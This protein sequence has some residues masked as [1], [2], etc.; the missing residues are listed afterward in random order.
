VEL[1]QVRG[2]LEIRITGLS[3]DSRTVKPG[4][5]FFALTGL[6]TDGHNFI[7]QAVQKG[8]IAVVQE[9]QISEN[10]ALPQIQ[11]RDSRR[12]LA[13]CSANYYFRPADYLIMFAVTGTDGKTT[14]CRLIQAIMSSYGPVGLMGTVGH[15]I[16]GKY[17]KA[18][19]TTPEAPEI[20]SLLAR[21]R[22]GGAYSAV[23]EVSSHALV[24]KRVEGIDFD[25]ATFTNLGLD[26]LDF[27]HTQES[28]FMAKALLF[29]NLKPRKCAIINID[30]PWGRRL[31][32]MTKSRILTYSLMNK[33]ADVFG[34]IIGSG[35]E[36][37]RM[38]IYFDG[39]L[40]DIHSSLIG[41]PNAY[42]L[43]SAVATTLAAKCVSSD[44]KPKV[45]DFQAVK[46]RFERIDC[47]IFTAVIDYAHTPQAIE[48]LL[49]T[50]KPL[51][52]GKLHIVFGCGGDRDRS[53]RPQMAYAAET[54]ADYLY[55]TTDNPRNEEPLKIIQDVLAGLKHPQ[56]AKII[57]DR[58]EAIYSALDYAHPDD[59]VI[60]AGKGHEDYQ[61]IA[62]IFHHLDDRE[63]VEEW[64]KIRNI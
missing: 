52:R 2:N 7:R 25:F 49:Q 19:R 60:I 24:L 47:G 64:V 44:L 30:D 41:L 9:S 37:I 12:A 54:L 10:L 50:L 59:L 36:G 63:I 42:N 29:E 38:N 51:C 4:D 40:I 34:E 18:P 11:V 15:L 13:L 27:H 46:G 28:Y 43:L 23:V 45:S 21:L 22:D 5:L 16:L 17:L 57:P 61:E 39:E 3:A 55:I 6:E 56:Q 53:K 48:K 31:L 33:N 35:L 20:H 32:G 1:I 26:H 58:R 62:G 8:A 14:T